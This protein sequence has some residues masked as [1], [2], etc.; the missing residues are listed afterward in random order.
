MEAN[1]LLTDPIFRLE[2]P[3]SIERTDLPGL[4]AALGDDRALSLP[5]L[6]RHQEDAFHIFLCYLAAAVLC[7]QNAKDPVQD[8]TFWQKS[9]RELTQSEGVTDDS[10]WTLVVSDPA[11][12]AFMQP[13][14]P[15]SEGFTYFSL[16]AETPDAL[17]LL[18]TAK[19]HD[20]KSSRSA[21]SHSEDWVYALVSL[22]TMSGF[23]GSGN[24]G[25]ARMNGGHGSRPVVALIPVGTWGRRWRS[26]V[27][28]L[29]EIREELLD[30]AWHYRPDGVVLT[31][32][33]SWDR[34]SSIAV[35][36][37]DPFFI[38]VCRA[39]RLVQNKGR[40]VAWG[41]TSKTPRLA[42]GEALGVLGDPWIPV[43]LEGKKGPQALTVGPAGLSAEL[44]RNLLF[45]EDGGYRPA[46]MQQPPAGLKEDP[47][48]FSVSVFV[49]G[50]GT[51]EGLQREEIPIPPQAR[52]LLFNSGPK[53]EALVTR[54]RRALENAGNL[55]SRVLKPAVLSFLEGAGGSQTID[56]DQ[57]QVNTWWKK[58][59]HTFRA[60]WSTELFPWLWRTA[61]EV[62]D[63]KADHAW[64]LSLRESGQDALHTVMRGYPRRQGRH[65]RS[66]AVAEDIFMGSLYKQFPQ[67][68]EASRGATDN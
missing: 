41:A 32:A 16:K 4:L 57:R 65:F 66:R 46:A 6:Q 61:E 12:P 48:R 39:V 37:L 9:I 27:A 30:G 29:L 19:N 26:D 56:W 33:P 18:P 22:Q 13:P 44:L 42:A 50:Q 23:F 63:E 53:R 38:E 40:L 45:F 20:V 15:G 68:K 36:S 64:L 8:A 34:K 14:A 5:G 52:T 25:I 3:T 21:C 47:V 1:N 67:L 43:K 60:S 24:Y 62:D 10:A 7:R 54:S 58:A 2:Y 11:R 28:R 59:A 31:W 55:E 49:R 51:T 17:D 35:S